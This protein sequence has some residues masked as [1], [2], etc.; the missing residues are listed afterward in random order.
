[1]KRY[2]TLAL[3][4][5]ALAALLLTAG[6][7]SASVDNGSSAADGR[8]TSSAEAIARL[9]TE[10]ALEQAAP[11]EPQILTEPPVL[12]LETRSEMV[13]AVTMLSVGGYSWTYD[14][15]NGEMCTVITDTMSAEQAAEG[16][17]IKA[18]IDA[19]ELAEA[20]KLLLAEGGKIASAVY[21]R[22]GEEHKVDFSAEGEL[23]LE[24]I[25]NDAVYEITVEFPQG[26][27][28]YRFITRERKSAG[29]S[30]DSSASVPPAEPNTDLPET[31]AVSSAYVPEAVTE[32]S[33][34]AVP[35]DPVELSLDEDG[36]IECPIHIY[37]TQCDFIGTRTL[38]SAAE[39]SDAG[40]EDYA[41]RYGEEFFSENVL[42]VASVTESSGSVHLEPVGVS[43]DY[44]VVLERTVPMIGTRDMAYY[45]VIAE[46]PLTLADNDLTLRLDTDMEEL[47]GVLW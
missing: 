21:F 26:Q 12:R 14:A 40:L 28:G 5:L 33:A 16:G 42:V 10:I 45:T 17:H 27:C 44:E 38:R 34:E 31:G 35:V 41:A 19:A 25:V 29:S 6:C 18:V 13:A 39:L 20:P 4:T 43:R 32:V 7:S 46:V 37:R 22:D 1:M 3:A 9:E 23:S 15:G 8:D 11:T 47:D 36:M 30:G 2:A 24:H